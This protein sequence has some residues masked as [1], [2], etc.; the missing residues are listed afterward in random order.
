VLP[1]LESVGVSGIRHV[2]QAP[3]C[4][5]SQKAKAAQLLIRQIAEK[6]RKQGSL[7]EARSYASEL[8]GNSVHIR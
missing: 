2:L 3:Q 5:R 7:R 1:K 8:T 6:P 4:L